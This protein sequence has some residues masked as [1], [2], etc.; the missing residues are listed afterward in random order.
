VSGADEAERAYEHHY[1]VQRSEDNDGDH[2]V[3]QLNVK[4]VSLECS[5]A[6]TNLVVEVMST[7]TVV[8]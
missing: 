6:R 3:L 2:E 1:E 8:C 5:A 4:F 7:I